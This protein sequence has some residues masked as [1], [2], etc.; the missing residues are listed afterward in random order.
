MPYEYK[1]IEHQER[2]SFDAEIN[3][4][5]ADG[6]STHSFNIQSNP[7]RYIALMGRDPNMPVMD[8]VG[9]AFTPSRRDSTPDVALPP[10]PSDPTTPLDTPADGDAV[11]E[12]APAADDSD[13][14]ETGKPAE[15]AEPEAPTTGTD[16]TPPQAE[17]PAPD[18]PAQE[19]E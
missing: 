14:G 13:S 17:D 2:G 8:A 5:S 9:R 10:S 1:T 3:A 4:L 16:E 7:T 11:T 18:A 15:P 12:P 19:S 6:W